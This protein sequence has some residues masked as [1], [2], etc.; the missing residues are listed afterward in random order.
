MSKFNES[1]TYGIEIEY[2]FGS[3]RAT[4]MQAM[5]RYLSD[6]GVPTIAAGYTH[7]NMAT[8][9]IVTD[10]SVYNG[11][12]LVSPPMSGIESKETLR[13]ALRVIK[14]HGARTHNSCGIH[15]HQYAGDLNGKQLAN[16]AELYKRH[17]S[18][19]DL[20]V[21][22]SR[23]GLNPNWCHS[24]I[25]GVEHYELMSSRSAPRTIGNFATMTP[26]DKDRVL[27]LLA[28]RGRY[29]KVNYVPYQR[30]G[31]VEFRQHHSSLNINKLWAWIVFTQAV[32]EIAKTKRGKINGRT[33]NTGPEATRPVRSL[34]REM[35]MR[36]ARDYDEVT[37]DAF[38]RLM[39][40]LPRTMRV[41][42]RN[43]DPVN[44]NTDGVDN[45]AIAAEMVEHI[46]ERGCP[47]CGARMI[48]RI[49]DNTGNSFMGC[50]NYR[51]TGCRGTRE[52]TVRV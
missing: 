25:G 35:G 12:E 30:Q 17:E 19:I 6:A 45:S 21:A 40:R 5:A 33:V 34:L 18:V 42:Y 23:R 13:T 9:K 50:T 8:W 2:S 32:V 15:I 48:R 44:D 49:N 24:M 3:G 47:Q 27:A 22:E 31:T 14:E 43:G 10:G 36:K 28:P 52:A 41:N 39:K 46:D 16:I 26:N 11:F 37:L 20:F 29:F 7:T 4:T 51:S 1:R 38:K